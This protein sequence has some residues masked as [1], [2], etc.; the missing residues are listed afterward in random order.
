MKHLILLFLIGF[1]LSI[2]K[3]SPVEGSD[4]LNEINDKN[5]T[6]ERD[7][8]INFETTIG[9]N[10]ETTS[11]TMS[12]II[13]DETTA[14]T[15]IEKTSETISQTITD[16]TTP[17]TNIETSSKSSVEKTSETNDAMSPEST[18]E[19]NFET[20]IATS[21][22]P[23]SGKTSNETSETNLYDRVLH[24]FYRPYVINSVEETEPVKVSNRT[25]KKRSESMLYNFRKPLIFKRQ[26]NARKPLVIRSIIKSERLIKNLEDKK[27]FD[28]NMGR[29]IEFPE[30][31]ED[32]AIEDKTGEDS[33]GRSLDR[34]RK[35][36][37]L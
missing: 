8:K 16:E 15:N 36:L 10:I 13:T 26:T 7:T 32:I 28:Q 24:K 11:E 3:S 1:T 20:N 27:T 12:Q 4:G 22:E 23:T 19:K 21:S 35:P 5:E 29:N 9:T 31:E 37:L 30:D 2:V 6:I 25:L 14:V 18:A 33:L 34:A 17:V